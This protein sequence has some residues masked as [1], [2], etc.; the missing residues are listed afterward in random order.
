LP[1]SALVS[2][3]VVTDAG[4]AS[5]IAVIGNDSGVGISNLWRDE[6]TGRRAV[7]FQGGSAHRYPIQ[8]VRQLLDTDGPLVQLM[9][10][11]NEALNI[12][13]AQTAFCNAHHSPLQ[14]VCR[15]ILVCKDR[16]PMRVLR[17]PPDRIP[18]TAGIP[19][20]AVQEALQTLEA[21]RAVAWNG[22][23]LVVKDEMAVQRLGCACHQ[24]IRQETNHLL[25]AF[26]TA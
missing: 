21:T 13:I 15:W 9:L 18:A 16:I 14:R 7:V 1:D 4:H 5:E 22:G 3:Q 26:E 24:L 20:P 17:L 25:K 2:L 19:A 6:I 8:R 12:Q 23:E 10:R 11:A